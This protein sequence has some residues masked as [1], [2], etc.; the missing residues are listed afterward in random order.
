MCCQLTIASAGPATGGAVASRIRAF[1]WGLTR[2][3][4][5]VDSRALEQAGV[6]G[7]VQP[8]VVLHSLCALHPVPSSV[9]VVTLPRAWEPAPVTAG[10]VASAS[11]DVA[12]T[13][14]GDRLRR[15]WRHAG[16]TE[17]R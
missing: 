3:G 1:A 14:M 17:R 4:W 15:Q 10:A 2:R 8:A 16:P 13:P 6:E 5:C 9:V 11:T 12:L 7:D